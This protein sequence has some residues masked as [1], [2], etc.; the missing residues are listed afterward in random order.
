[1]RPPQRGFTLIELMIVISIIG[2]LASIAIPQYQ[3]Y[4]TRT[5]ISEGLS[6]AE[7][8]KTAVAKTFQSLGHMP[9]GSNTVPTN[10]FDLP[11]AAS[12]SGKYVANITVTGGT[13]FIAYNGNV[14]GGVTAGQI[15]TL[16]P[17]A[18]PK[19]SVAWACGYE[20]LA[21]N[22]KTVGGPAS[23]TTVPAKL[24]GMSFRQLRYRIKKWGWNNPQYLGRRSYH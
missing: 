15:L 18:T 14:G 9:A 24:L 6:L 5:K 4:V 2:V 3:D 21:L 10:S 20:S 22:G 7:A 12:I 16:T 8:A 11:A 19:A 13:I 1:M 23:G 17:L